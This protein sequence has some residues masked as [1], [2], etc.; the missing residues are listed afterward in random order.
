M[1]SGIQGRIQ[2]RKA[3]EGDYLADILIDICFTTSY[4]VEE[5]LV[6]PPKRL[7]RIIERFKERFYQEA[8]K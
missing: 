6:M 2:K 4:K 1:K 5:L 7:N 8:K 3:E